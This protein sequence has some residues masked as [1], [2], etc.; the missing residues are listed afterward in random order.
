MAQMWTMCVPLGDKAGSFRRLFHFHLPF[1]PRPL[2]FQCKACMWC[3][4]FGGLWNPSFDPLLNKS[5]NSC[6]QLLRLSADSSRI[7]RWPEGTS[8][9]KCW[10][11]LSLSLSFSHWWAHNSS[12]PVVTSLP[13]GYFQTNVFHHWLGFS[14]CSQWES[15]LRSLTVAAGHR[16]HQHHAFR[17]SAY[18]WVC[19]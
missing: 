18:C 2:G 6:V 10:A 1:T 17:L 4:L 16:G 3:H 8:G 5:V 19:T 11:P 7:S 9:L 14:S 15:R 13:F 12:L